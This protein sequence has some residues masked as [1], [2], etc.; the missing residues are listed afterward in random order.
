MVFQDKTVLITGGTGSLGKKLISRIMQGDLGI[1]KKI[2]IFSR[3]E[4]KQHQM[5]L[6]WKH[7]IVATDEIIYRVP[8]D[9]LEFQIGD[10]RDY[11]TVLRV[12]SRADIIINAAALKQVPTCEYFPYEAVRT[13]IQGA[14]NIVTAVREAGLHVETVVGVSTDK[15][16]KPVNVMGMSKAIQERILIRGNIDCPKTKFI[17]VRYGNVLAS[18]GSVIPLFLYQIARGGPVTITTREMTRFLLSLDQAIHLIFDAIRYAKKGETFIPKVP[19]VNIVDLAD[20]LIGDRK[21]IKRF[22]GIRPGEKIDEVLISEEECYRTVEKKG[23]YVIE[24]ILPELRTEDSA[25]SILKREY[26]SAENLVS[27]E[28][29]R[30]LLKNNGL[31]GIERNIEAEEILR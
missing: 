20:V 2:I 9:I 21:I 23:Y 27:K 14:H 5:R 22:I 15:A 29:V 6:E 10:I 1:P 4:A 26:T 11:Q 28:E 7:K 13:N 24:P 18:R 31:L 3:D 19:S 8:E 17:C 12:A 16:C 30:E 25:C